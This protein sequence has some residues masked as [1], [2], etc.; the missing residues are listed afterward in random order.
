TSPA[1]AFFAGYPATGAHTYGVETRAGVAGVDGLPAARDVQV[2]GDGANVYVA[3]PGDG[4]VAVFARELAGPNLGSLTFVQVARDGAG[5]FEGLAG[6]NALA[7]APD[8]F[9][10]YVSGGGEDA[11]AVLRRDAAAGGTL[12][13]VGVERQGFGQVTG[14]AGPAGVALTPDGRLLLATG[15]V[16]DAVV[17]FARPVDSF[18]S[19][20]AGTVLHDVVNIAAGSRIVYTITGI[21]SPSICAPPYPCATPLVN[22]ASVAVPPGTT[23]PTPGNNTD[24]DQDD[25]SVRVN[26][27][28]LKTDDIATLRGLEGA[29]AAAVSPDGR[30]LYAVGQVGDAV[31]VLRRDLA[32]GAL[33]FR[34]SLRDGVGGVDGL[35]GAAAVAIDPTGVHVY[36]AGSA[37]N[38]VA[39]FRREA[40][41]A[42]PAFGELTFVER[43]Q[44]GFGGVANLLGPSSLALTD[45]GRFLYA[46]ASGSSAVVLFHRNVDAESG[47]FGKL[48]YGGAVVD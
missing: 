27:Q 23:D 42:S 25:I 9:N 45:D 41:S 39:V 13:F 29:R 2:S 4:A 14:L 8:G 31:V 48:A 32:T 16:A 35:N 12:A 21:L 20:G 30:H 3:G 46:A 1:L 47:S 5:G 19:G 7:V 34:Q 24:I 22:Q 33:T 10:V 17:A 36:V 11:V 43:L 18:C 44:N 37:D 40:D 15:R 26:L 28:I 6:A 38:A